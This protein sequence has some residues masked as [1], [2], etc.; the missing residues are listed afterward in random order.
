MQFVFFSDYL[1][2]IYIINMI[3]DFMRTQNDIETLANDAIAIVEKTIKPYNRHLHPILRPILIN[4]RAKH[5]LGQ[6]TIRTSFGVTTAIIQLSA[7]LLEDNV[8]DN[9][10]L[11]TLVHEVLH[12]VYGCHGHTGDWRRFANIIN[13]EYNYLNITARASMQELEAN[14]VPTEQLTRQKDY[15]YAVM[16]NGCG[17]TIRR[18]KLS[19]IIT[20]PENYRCGN[21]GGTFHKVD[22]ANNQTRKVL[23]NF[24]I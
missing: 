3:G 13:K 9:Y 11:E 17:Q 14:G 22:L 7:L 10:V 20:N 1:Y 6:C 24:N 23:N 2:N 12:A 5:R 18:T 16:C 19:K 4:A 15:K 21:C 8:P